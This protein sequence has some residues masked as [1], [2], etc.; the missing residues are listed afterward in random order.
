MFKKIKHSWTVFEQNLA[1]LNN[2]PYLLE[3]TWLE[4][5]LQ[6]NASFIT[7]QRIPDYSRLIKSISM[8]MST[9]LFSVSSGAIYLF[10]FNVETFT[11]P[12]YILMQVYVHRYNPILNHIK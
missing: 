10:H 5:H 2:I 9:Y 8:Q 4:Q 1:S 11:A 7:D 3:M 6:I 12:I